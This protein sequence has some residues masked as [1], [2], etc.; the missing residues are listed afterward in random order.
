MAN[1]FI[2]YNRDSKS[3]AKT[4]IE[5]IQKLGHT[6]WFDQKLSGGQVWWDKI[7]ESIR[8]CDVERRHGYS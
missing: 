1:I 8:E 4:L 3:I 6:V 2:S 5:D 7:L